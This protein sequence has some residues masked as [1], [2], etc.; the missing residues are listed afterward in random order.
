MRRPAPTLALLVAAAALLLAAPAAALKRGKPPRKETEY[1]EYTSNELNRMRAG[2]LAELLR[3]RNVDCLRCV[4][5][6]DMVKHLLDA[7]E[8]RAR[9]LKDRR[10]VFD[11]GDGRDEYDLDDD[12]AAA[13]DAGAKESIWDRIGTKSALG[14]DPLQ[15]AQE[16][17]NDPEELRKVMEQAREAGG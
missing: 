14:F 15:R 1:R 3:A 4:H 9:K 11:L 12:G 6:S 13:G 16:I 8:E 5:K 2:Q 10:P 17:A 7:Q